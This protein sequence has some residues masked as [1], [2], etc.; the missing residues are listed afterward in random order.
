[1]GKGFFSVCHQREPTVNEKCL[2]QTFGIYIEMYIV[3]H[4]KNKNKTK[5][6]FCFRTIPLN[7][8]DF[9]KILWSPNSDCLKFAAVEMN[10]SW[11]DDLEV[12]SAAVKLFIEK[13]TNQDWTLRVG[14][15]NQIKK[16][17]AEVPGK[18][19]LFTFR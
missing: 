10:E 7:I 9:E 1:M 4:F 17:L 2:S 3:L 13:A 6:N 16:N 5:R 12:L 8:R 14:W 19:Q 15:L 18:Y 11:A